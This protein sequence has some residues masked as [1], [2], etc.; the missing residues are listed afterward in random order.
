MPCLPT[1]RQTKGIVTNFKQMKALKIILIIVGIFILLIL[2][3]FFFPGKITIERSLTM[4]A[5]VEMIYDQVNNLRNWEQWSPWH[6]ID[7]AMKLKYN[8]PMGVGGS[9][10]WTSDHPSVGNGKLTITDAKA[11]EFINT[12]MDW[13]DQGTGTASFKFEENDEGVTVTWDMHSDLGNN[14]ITRW[15]GALMIKPSV[16]KAYD[17]GLAD[18]AAQCDFLQTQDWFYVKIKTKDDIAYYGIMD[19]VSMAEMG[20]KMGEFYHKIY[21]EMGKNKIEAKGSPFAIYHTWGETVKM[22]CAVP[23]ED[24]SKPL[25]GI[26]SKTLPTNKYAVIK[27][28]GPYEKSEKPH[29]YMDKWLKNNQIEMAGPVVEFYKVGPM[30]EQ[31]SNKYVTYILYTIK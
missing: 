8:I 7:T 12:E 31:D 25:K 19:E 3:G 15:F 27:Y 23:V 22:E 6:K 14:P 2:A 10:E 26:D 21:T 28:V 1:D 29:V 13:G 11:F 20:D 16:T 9:Y 24:N 30:E 18:I 4:K 5:P 17:N